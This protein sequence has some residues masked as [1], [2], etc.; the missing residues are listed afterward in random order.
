M[1]KHGKKFIDAHA[2][3]STASVCTRRPRHST[4]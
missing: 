1:T 3:A 4:S 2:H